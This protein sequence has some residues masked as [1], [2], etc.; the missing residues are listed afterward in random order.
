MGATTVELGHDPK[1]ASALPYDGVAS[2]FAAASQVP[3][4]GGGGSLRVEFSVSPIVLSRNSELSIT[5]RPP[6]FEPAKPYAF[7]SARAREIVAWIIR[8]SLAPLAY[9]RLRI[10]RGRREGTMGPRTATAAVIA[11]LLG[12]LAVPPQP[13]PHFTDSYCLRADFKSR[14]QPVRAELCRATRDRPAGRSV[15]VLHGCGG[16]STFDH[17]LAV[18]LPVY[19]ISTL[20]VDY[21]AA[22][23]P[24]GTRGFCPSATRDLSPA[25]RAAL[26]TRWVALVDDAAAALARTPNVVS[27]HVGVVGWSL[28]GG[29][30][31]E[32]AE[33]S[34]RF[35]A[36]AAFSTGLFGPPPPGLSA[37]PPTLLLSG[38]T[39][40]A[41]PLSSTLAL[42]RAA[43]KA[44]A[45]VSL[46]VYPHGSHQWPRAQGAA[47]IARAARF[48]RARL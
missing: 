48:L 24:R 20:Y 7:R 44:G 17:R 40:D 16:F 11:A 27:E 30:A 42:Y 35:H 37:L 19:G 13:F 29:L 10:A 31:V 32:A 22:T 18:T 41:V 47:G 1:H 43:G 34:R 21:F 45:K 28:G 23:P 39:T 3:S 38:G 8:A 6:E 12:P 26:F 9:R 4:C 36:V 2:R 5:R 33:S 15:V 14:G 25:R 46:F